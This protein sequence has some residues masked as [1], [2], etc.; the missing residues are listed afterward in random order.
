MNLNFVVLECLIG[1]GIIAFAW[2]FLFANLRRDNF[3]SEIRLLRDGLF[4]FMW[5]NGYSFETPAYRETRQLLNGILRISN[6]LGPISFVVN[7]AL[8]A[9]ER[10]ER[11]RREF[12]RCEDDRLQSELVRIRNEASK[13]TV[14]FVFFQ[15]IFGLFVRSLA[16]VLRAVHYTFRFK[17]WM[18]RMT[19]GLMDFAHFM[20]RPDLT[21]GTFAQWVGAK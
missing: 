9:A 14:R 10:D 20:G 2:F 7:F 8:V 19:E 5:K 21:R 18:V 17:Q 15:G 6:K 13:M 4:D 16:T 12:P 11:T 3:R 1:V